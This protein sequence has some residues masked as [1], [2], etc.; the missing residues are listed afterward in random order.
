MM[1]A[2]LVILIEQLNRLLP[3]GPVVA[4]AVTRRGA[5]GLARVDLCVMSVLV[6]M[7]TLAMSYVTTLCT[8]QLFLRGAVQ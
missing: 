2:L 7:S 6:M 5:G 8:V 3:A 4:K 1:T